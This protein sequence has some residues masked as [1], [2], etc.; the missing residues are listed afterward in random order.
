MK[1]DRESLEREENVVSCSPSFSSFPTSQ[2]QVLQWVSWNPEFP[3]GRNLKLK[4][5]YSNGWENFYKRL[6]STRTCVTGSGNMWQFN[7]DQQLFLL[8]LFDLAIICLARQLNHYL[9]VCF[10]FKSH[11][12]RLI[13][14]TLPTSAYHWGSKSVFRGI[15]NRLFE[16]SASFSRSTE[17]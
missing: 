11:M 13:H 12:L 10:F 17:W 5:H 9:P 4:A 16:D 7:K 1:R 8:N 3:A 6:F 15:L 14:F 2:V